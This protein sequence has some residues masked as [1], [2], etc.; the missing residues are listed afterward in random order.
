LLFGA[1]ANESA[2]VGLIR[3]TG[4]DWVRQD[5]AMPFADRVGGR[6]TDEYLRNRALVQSWI[7]QGL[8]VMG[9][10]PRPFG[11]SYE[12]DEQGVL[13][14]RVKRC[15]PE[16][17]GAPGSEAYNRSYEEICAWLAQDLKGL[18]STWQIANELDIELF[19]GP[20]TARQACEFIAHGARGLKRTDASSVVGHNPA[21]CG[22]HSD[23]FYGWFYGGRGALLDYCGVDGY[24]GTWIDGGPE[25]WDRRLAELRE[26]TGVPILVNEWGFSSEGAQLAPGELP[27]DRTPCQVRKWPSTWGPGHTPEG[28]AAFVR[29]CFDVFLKHRRSLL[30]VF[31]YRWEDQQNCWQC[32]RADCPMETRWGLVDLD[33]KPKPAWTAY[34]E[35]LAAMKAAEE[36]AST[37]GLSQGK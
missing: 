6:L 13:R 19:A 32:G 16:W 9:V 2:D 18:I 27:A 35:G 5:L 37:K 17:C 11:G 25:S 21:G 22:P 28:Q 20:L 29:E 10:T 23:Y 3:K 31:F 33:G 24:Y 14:L 7:G 30:G 26:L 1:C 15:L 4:I 12:P 8:K 34:K 36:A